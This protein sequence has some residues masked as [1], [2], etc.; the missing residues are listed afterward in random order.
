M[1]RTPEQDKIIKEWVKA[2]NDY[3]RACRELPEY[4]VYNELLLKHAGDDP[5]VS[6]DDIE[7]AFEDWWDAIEADATC[8]VLHQKVKETSLR[9]H[10]ADGFSHI[11]EEDRSEIVV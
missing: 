4:A 8:H 2:L 3:N 10:H 5:E 6:E 1:S 7:D 11:T 9:L